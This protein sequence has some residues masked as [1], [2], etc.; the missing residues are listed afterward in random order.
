MVVVVGIEDQ[1]L[2]WLKGLID[3]GGEGT[4]WVDC[5]VLALAVS[6]RGPAAIEFCFGGPAY[7]KPVHGEMGVVPEERR[8]T[9]SRRSRAVHGVCEVLREIS[10]GS[11]YLAM[12]S[13][14]SLASCLAAPRETF[15]S[16]THQVVVHRQPAPQ[17]YPHHAACPRGHH[18][19]FLVLH[20]VT[21][22]K[23]PRVA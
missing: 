23:P 13:L 12:T 11:S 19:A 3:C 10:P 5:R 16:M 1:T 22:H 21:P 2:I 6:E 4:G 7:S 9:E 17:T 20:R 18:I 8:P 14:V 15:Q